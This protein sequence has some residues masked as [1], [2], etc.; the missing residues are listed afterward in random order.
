MQL[1]ILTIPDSKAMLAP[2]SKLEMHYQ[3]PQKFLTWGP[4]P[5]NLETPK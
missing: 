1:E 4:A 3:I 2:K 5:S